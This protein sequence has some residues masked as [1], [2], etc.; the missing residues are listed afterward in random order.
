MHNAGSLRTGVVRE[1]GVE[2]IR[3]AS[4]CR[5]PESAIGYVAKL[6]SRILAI[7]RPA[8]EGMKGRVASPIGRNA[9]DGAKIYRSA[10]E[11]NS[12]Q[13]TGTITRQ[14]RWRALSVETSREGIEYR[15][16]TCRS[17]PV[18]CSQIIGATRGGGSVKIAVG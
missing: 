1:D 15:L 7:C 11:G 4:S 13:K 3:T 12:I 18:D 9:K 8:G 10:I 6:H 5:T 17:Y 14:A 2:S 16:H